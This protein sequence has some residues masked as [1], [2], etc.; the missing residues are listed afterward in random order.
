MA[1]VVLPTPAI[2]S[3]TTTVAAVVVCA[4]TTVSARDAE[5]FLAAGEV[6]DIAR[7][8]VQ[9]A[10]ASPPGAG[11][12]GKLRV[13]SEDSLLNVLQAGARLGAQFADQALAS[14]PVGVQGLRL[15][16]RPVQSDHELLN[17][18]LHERVLRD[19]LGQFPGQLRLFAQRELCCDA[20]QS[21]RKTLLLEQAAGPSN[22]VTRQSRQRFTPPEPVPVAK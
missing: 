8:V 20:V 11:W 1:R 9:S 17:Q 15:A 10:V 18:R 2:P 14:L 12:R 16:T 5:F 22:P 3:I 19:E 6:W 13:A 7:K 21:R 4:A